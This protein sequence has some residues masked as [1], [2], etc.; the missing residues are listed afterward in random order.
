VSAAPGRAME[1]AAPLPR[2]YLCG[3]IAE[4]GA[5]A[6]GGYQACNRRSIEALRH[7]GVDV[8]ALP[9]PHPH[10]RGW[11]KHVEYA[12]GFLRLYGRMLGCER[13]SILHLTA[14]A[15]HFVYNEWPLL[16]LARLRG[17]RIVYD[18]RAGAGQAQ[19]EARSACYRWAF[20]S[21]LQ[22]AHELMVEGEAL[23][24]FV[25]RLAR[26]TP[27]H[28]P[29]HID[30]DALPWRDTTAAL[31]AAPTIAYVGRIV[32]EKGIETVLETAGLLRRGGLEV[33]LLVAGDGDPGYLHRLREASSELDVRWLGP[34]SSVAVLAL[35]REAH[36]FVFPTRHVGEGQSNALTEA[37]AC[38]CVPLA[39]RHGFNAAVIG[40]AAL[41]LPVDAAARAYVDALQGLWP[42]RWAL[43]SE[44]M[45]RRARENFSTA[46]V[47][48]TLLAVYRRAVGPMR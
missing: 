41:T 28:L 43:L 20:R 45:Q 42:E 13:G 48:A 4:A 30:T 23:R 16:Q 27:V 6:R 18:L 39:S 14:L 25:E 2:V 33:R 37:M 1:D 8:V 24:P 32:A 22:A 7:A 31:P 36:F 35:W 19:Y 12:L 5:A 3:P 11:R 9:Y 44:R 26:R 47:V 17:L 10:A 29:N 21:C 40:D 34:L 15:V 38:G 46:A